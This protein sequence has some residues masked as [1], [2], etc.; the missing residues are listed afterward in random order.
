MSDLRNYLGLLR[1]SKV[2]KTVK[3]SVSTKYEIAAITAKADGSHA[4]LFEK[5]KGK[6][7]TISH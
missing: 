2:L 1:K 4:V 6:K 7:R 5:I 3:K